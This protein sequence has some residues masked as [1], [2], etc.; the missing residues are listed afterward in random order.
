MRREMHGNS[1]V[2]TYEELTVTDCS[3]CFC[4]TRFVC[5]LWITQSSTKTKNRYTHLACGL[6]FLSP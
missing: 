4:L 3:V 2:N 1:D 5:S 6:T